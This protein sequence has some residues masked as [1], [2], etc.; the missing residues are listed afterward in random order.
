VAEKLSGAPQNI[1]IFGG[2]FNPPHL[3]H[4]ALAKEAQKEFSLDKIFFIPA[5]I[6]PHKEP[7]NVIDAEHRLAMVKLLINGDSGLFLSD[8][9]IKKRSVSYS[10]ET[11]RHFKEEYPSSKI[12]FLIGSD[13]F[14]HIDT[15]KESQELLKIIDFIIFPRAGNTKEMIAKKFGNL[16]NVVYWAHTSL[17][18]ISSTDIR[19]RLRSGEEC[20]IELGAGVAAYIKENKLYI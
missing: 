19:Y 6:P 8:Y 9:E 12:H 3:G 1:G 2:T 16:S 17:V 4:L 5:F 15:W 20:S 11:I 7:R 10:I 18:H 14:Y 13:A